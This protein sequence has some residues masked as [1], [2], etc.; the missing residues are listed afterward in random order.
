MQ[1]FG[2]CV[3]GGNSPAIAYV[4]KRPWHELGEQLPEGQPIEIWREAAQL[5]WELM[6]LPFI[7]RKLW[8]CLN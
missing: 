6:R 7:I 2:R 1:V 5:D 8:P 4:G 3:R